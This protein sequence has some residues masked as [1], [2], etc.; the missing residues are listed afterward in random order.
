MSTRSRAALT[1]KAGAALQ[2]AL[3]PPGVQRTWMLE[4][5][6]SGGCSG[7]EHRARLAK[8]TLTLLLKGLPALPHFPTS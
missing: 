1:A 6:S 4:D 5:S 3:E 8:V 2:L 7:E